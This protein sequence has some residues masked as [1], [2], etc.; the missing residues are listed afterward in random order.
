MYDTEALVNEALECG[1]SQAGE[2]NVKSLVFMPE[3]QEMCNPEACTRY[4]T[5]WQ[6]PPACG[7][8]EEATKRAAQYSYGIIF[9]TTGKLEDEFDYESIRDTYKKH[10]EN[11]ASLVDKIKIRYPDVLPMGAGACEICE[12]CTYPNE[13][14]RFPD[15]AIASM[16]A[17]GLWVS[18]VCQISGIPYNYGELTMTY[19]SCYLLK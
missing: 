4:N 12:T 7:S 15:K 10:K 17:Y 9:Q 1:F 11:L 18:K 8:A 2:L 13:P 14:C 3:I 5:N 6:C 16:E 19:T